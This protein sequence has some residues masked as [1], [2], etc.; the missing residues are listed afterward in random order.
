MNYWGLVALGAAYLI[1][2]VPTGYILFRLAAGG[3]LREHGSGN[4]GA[5]NAFRAAGKMVGSIT[6]AIDMGKGALAVALARTVEGDVAWAAGAAFAAVLGHCYPIYLRFKGGKG[7]ATGCGA[8]AVLAPVPVGI[9]FAIFLAGML[10]TRMVSVGS[11][12][13][14]LSLPLLLYWSRPDRAVM[15]SACAAVL[16]VVAKHHAN[17]RRIL[18]GGEHRIHGS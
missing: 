8:L 17:I 15:I 9:A 18:A 2:A 13:A 12:C 16:L 1:G 5:T 11:I 3:D 10:L 14:G 6:L 4:V 7:V